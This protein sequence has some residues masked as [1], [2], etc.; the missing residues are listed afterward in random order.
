M[1]QSLNTITKTFTKESKMVKA[2]TD[3]KTLELIVE[4]N[5]QRAEISKIEKP[6]W[7]TSC[8]FSYVEGN[9]STINLHVESNV[10]NL[11]KIVA[12]LQNR[13]KSYNQASKDLGVENAPEFTWN[14][15]S[16]ADWI[17]DVKMRINKI[18]IADK[19]K[20]FETLEARLNAIIS[21]ELRAEIELEK[22]ANELK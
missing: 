6:N 16:V 5:R 14:G 12:F 18:Q 1:V 15:F 7:K 22:I 21:P 3:K 9:N 10:R 13:E 4:V 8:S 20:K 17:E 11:I 19:K 2:K